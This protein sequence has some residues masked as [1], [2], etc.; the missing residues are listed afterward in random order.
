MQK[1]KIKIKD[2]HLEYNS[3]TEELGESAKLLIKPVTTTKHEVLN[4]LLQQHY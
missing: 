3:G 4:T 2:V 1:N